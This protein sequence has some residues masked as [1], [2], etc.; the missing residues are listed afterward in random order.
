MPNGFD[1]EI[2]HHPLTLKRVANIIVC[3]ERLKSRRSESVLSTE[4]RD[5]NL[6]S[7]IFESI[8]EGNH[9]HHTLLHQ[10]QT[11][12]KS[13]ARKKEIYLCVYV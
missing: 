2:V 5:E 9:T 10:K 3:L 12:P 1:L 7:F 6:L 4:F 8:V 11:Q 13:V